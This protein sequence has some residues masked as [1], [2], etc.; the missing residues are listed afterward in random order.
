[1]VCFF[2]LKRK[3]RGVELVVGKVGKIWEELEEGK[4][5]IRR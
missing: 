5:M 3:R 2:F 4:G 1:L